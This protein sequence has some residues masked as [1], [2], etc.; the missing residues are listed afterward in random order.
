MILQQVKL[1]LQYPIR[2]H[3]EHQDLVLG[4]RVKMTTSLLHHQV[5]PTAMEN[6]NLEKEDLDRNQVKILYVLLLFS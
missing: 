5:A 2:E 6:N 4:H 3:E 1:V